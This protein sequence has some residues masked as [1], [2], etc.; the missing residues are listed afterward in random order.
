[1]KMAFGF[2]R[3]VYARRSDDPYNIRRLKVNGFMTM[4]KF[5]KLV[6]NY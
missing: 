1:M 4:K 3:H 6:R 2:D 5:R